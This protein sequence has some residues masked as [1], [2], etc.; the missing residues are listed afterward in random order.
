MIYEEAASGKS[1]TRPE[2]EPWPKVAAGGWIGLA[3][4]SR[5][6]TDRG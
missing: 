1:A 4:V 6:F 3:A 2:L 5:P